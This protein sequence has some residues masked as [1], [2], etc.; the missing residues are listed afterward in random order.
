MAT[1][2][3][4]GSKVRF[5]GRRGSRQ[6]HITGVNANGYQIDRGR[7]VA[8]DHEG[9]DA[10]REVRVVDRGDLDGA[11]AGTADVRDLPPQRRH[12]TLVEAF[13]RLAPDEGFVLVNDH[14][15]KP[16]YYELRSTY[17]DV[18]GWEY[19]SRESGDIAS[20][21]GKATK[22]KMADGKELKF[23]NW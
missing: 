3:E 2:N 1:A 10:T 5:G 12:A 14:D 18:V 11:A 7:D 13:A 21:W 19:A 20:G 8:W 15:P 16:L 4:L 23:D 6:Y 9:D 17:G 22:M